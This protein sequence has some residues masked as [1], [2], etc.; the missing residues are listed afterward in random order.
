MESL[1]LIVLSMLAIESADYIRLLYRHFLS[2]VTEKSLNA[3]YYACPYANIDSFRFMNVT[4]RLALQFIPEL[5]NI[6]GNRCV[7]AYVTASNKTNKTRILFFST[8]APENIRM[9]CA[10]QQK[11]Y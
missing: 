2:K 8:I 6:F 1:F 9:A 11:G 3:F 10:W 7:H 5:T 4:T